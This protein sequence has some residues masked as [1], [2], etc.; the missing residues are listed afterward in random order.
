ML[1]RAPVEE[2]KEEEIIGHEKKNLNKSFQ[3]FKK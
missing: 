1:H 3:D 2:E